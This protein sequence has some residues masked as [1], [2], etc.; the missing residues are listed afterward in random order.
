MFEHRYE[1]SVK[2]VNPSV[3]K[4]YND[5]A[6]QYKNKYKNHPDSGF[7][8]IS[9][10]NTVDT[11]NEKNTALIDLG[12]QCSLT[13]ILSLDNNNNNVLKIPSAYYLYPRSS[14]YK[15][16]YRQSNNVGIID[17][18]Y[19]GNL[20]AAMDYHESLGRKK[21]EKEI[22]AGNRYWQI[23]TPTLEPIFNVQIV[24]NLDNT[25]RGNGGHG[26]TGV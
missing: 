10:H 9:P 12:I 19:R 6:L 22:I 20:M 4:Y 8:L 7:D 5:R 15:T 13:K 26:S 18:G 16:S 21:Y 3:F 24:E 25:S 11:H 17:S 14:I 2:V 23:C 1:L